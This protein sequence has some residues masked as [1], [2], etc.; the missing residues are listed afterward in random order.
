[1]R[2]ASIRL[3]ASLIAVGWEPVDGVAYEATEGGVGVTTGTGT[4]GAVVVDGVGIAG[5]VGVVCVAAERFAIVGAVGLGRGVA[6][7]RA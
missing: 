1:M 4:G 6:A 2:T 5:A 7:T 3:Q